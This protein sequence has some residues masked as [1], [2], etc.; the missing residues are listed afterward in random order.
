MYA[1]PRCCSQEK[2]QGNPE[3]GQELAPS[4]MCIPSEEC[5]FRIEQTGAAS[6]QL[7]PS[8]CTAHPLQAAASLT[9]WLYA[10]D[11]AL[12]ATASSSS[13]TL[14]TSLSWATSLTPTHL[15]A[16]VH[17]DGNGSDGAS[18]FTTVTAPQVETWRYAVERFGASNRNSNHDEDPAALERDDRLV[19][20]FRPRL[21]VDYER[22]LLNVSV[23]LEA[24]DLDATSLVF[25]KD[26]NALVI[27]LSRLDPAV[28]RSD[29][30]TTW[31][32]PRDSLS[33]MGC[34]AVANTLL[35]SEPVRL[36]SYAVEM[37]ESAT[38]IQE[39]KGCIEAR[40]KAAGTIVVQQAVANCY[41]NQLYVRSAGALV[42]FSRSSALTVRS[43]QGSGALDAYLFCAPD[44]VLRHRRFN[45]TTLRSVLRATTDA[46]QA[47]LAQPGDDSI[48]DAASA[49]AQVF[50]G[51]QELPQ[52]L[53]R[54]QRG[55]SVH[56]TERTHW[57]EWAVLPVILCMVLLVGRVDQQ[58][59][60]AAHH[61][62]GRVLGRSVDNSRGEMSS[63]ELIDHSTTT[64]RDGT[65]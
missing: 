26:D 11:S 27:G 29:F 6:A 1:R 46:M 15:T 9:A 25:A 47:R 10:E 18:C 19:S 12:L 61:P 23:H 43:P 53:W 31:Q 34:A 63:V 36:A 52:I 4:A 55:G 40:A 58:G 30:T 60:L 56:S 41:P 13:I 21:A 20:A 51:P 62:S 54:N 24:A 8:N 45:V 65:G 14:A 7:L 32:F 49:A 42:G 22:K 50:D 17:L 48:D 2:L 5:H 44:G 39:C 33:L 28:A 38:R 3:K 57:L 16:R 64:S 35:C 37:L 59:L